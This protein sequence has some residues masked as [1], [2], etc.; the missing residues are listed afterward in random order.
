MRICFLLIGGTGERLLFLGCSS[1]EGGGGL[2]QDG[3]EGGAGLL[4]V[5]RGGEGLL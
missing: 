1:G 3:G 4:R 5:G 2:L